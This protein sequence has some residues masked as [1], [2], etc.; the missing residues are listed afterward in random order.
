MSA[1]IVRAPA[2][3]TAR[4]LPRLAL[5][6]LV[7]VALLVGASAADAALT[8]D[9]C[10]AAKRKAAGTLQKCRATEEAKQL[11]GKP[12]NLAKCRTKFQDALTKSSAKATKAAIGC[13]YRDNGD[14][15]VTDFDTGL[16]WEQKNSPDGIAYFP[17]PHDAENQYTWSTGT[18]LA[19]GQIVT[20]F[21]SRLNGSAPALFGLDP[22]VSADGA[23]VTGGFAGHCDWRLPTI[24]ELQTILLVPSYPCGTSPCI[25]PIFGP[26]VAVGYWSATTNAANPGFAWSV[27]FGNGGVF[28]DGKDFTYYVRAVRTGL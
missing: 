2:P 13:R 20:E 15:T 23:T 25:D 6:P 7:G 26:T 8:T 12:A 22:C 11:Q 21:L 4:S 14:G 1:R 19:D 28:N 24:V 5:A 18:D 9:A 16:Q 10:L 3:R 27:G 17:N